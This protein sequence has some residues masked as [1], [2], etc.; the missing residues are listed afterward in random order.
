[1]GIYSEDD[2]VDWKRI[3]NENSSN[4]EKLLTLYL[5]DQLKL[6]SNDL[7]KYLTNKKNDGG[8]DA[9]FDIG[10]KII[11]EAKLRSNF[12]SDLKLADFAKSFIIAVNLSIDLIYIGT[13]N[14]LSDKT[15]KA[16]FEFEE[17]TGLLW[18]YIDPITIY[19]WL[20]RNNFDYNEK[21]VD[22][23]SLLKVSKEIYINKRF[24]TGSVIRSNYD[25]K[26]KQS[27]Y[28]S[29]GSFITKE[30]EKDSE[31][32]I[33]YLNQYNTIIV[34]GDAGSGKTF[35]I[36]KTFS[37]SSINSKHWQIIDLDLNNFS[38]SSILFI[39]ILECFWMFS[40]SLL[41]SFNQ[42]DLR[43]IFKSLYDDIDEVVF[44]SVLRAFNTEKKS[45]IDN[46]ILVK[47][48]FQIY[49]KI[50]S[51]RNLV[52]Y[53]QNANK[54]N[55]SVINFVIQ[56]L[57]NFSRYSRIV[58]EIRSSLFIDKRMTDD[59]WNSFKAEVFDKSDFKISIKDVD[60]V[61]IEKYIDNILQK[62]VSLSHRIKKEIIAHLGLSPLLIT[63]YISYLNL[64]YCDLKKETANTLFIFIKSTLKNH[65]EEKILDLSFEAL[66]NRNEAYK[67]VFYFAYLFGG[68]IPIQLIKDYILSNINRTYGDFVNELVLANLFEDVQESGILCIKHLLL[69][70]C[71]DFN[72]HKEIMPNDITAPSLFLLDNINRYDNIN[73]NLQS[74]KIKIYQ[75]LN[76][77]EQLIEESFNYAVRLY[78]DGSYQQ[79]YH[80]AQISYEANQKYNKTDKSKCVKYLAYEIKALM[81]IIQVSG[82]IKK[83]ALEFLD[84]R[85]KTVREL[86]ESNK[87]I[88]A[89]LQTYYD[90]FGHYSMILARHY[91]HYGCYEMSFKIMKI[92]YEEISVNSNAPLDI[93]LHIVWEYAISSKHYKGLDKEITILKSWKN[94]FPESDG[95]NIIYHTAVYQKNIFV[96]PKLAL[97]NI[98]DA[99][100]YKEI[101]KEKATHIH[102]DVH[103]WNA[104]TVLENYDIVWT[105]INENLEG[106]EE[107]GLSNELGRC[108]HILAFISSI[109]GNTDW[110]VKYYKKAIK[111][112][113][114][115]SYVEYLWTILLDYI[116]FNIRS[117]TMEDNNLYLVDHLIHIICNTYKFQIENIVPNDIRYSQIHMC[118]IILIY[119]LKKARYC[120]L[121]KIINDIKNNITCPAINKYLDISCKE[122][123]Y[124]VLIEKTKYYHDGFLFSG[125]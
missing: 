97:L 122:Q 20:I 5:I 89:G 29:L 22:L 80:Y 102:L 98:N 55:Y 32:M 45:A 31:E 101:N 14:H 92:A 119:E 34:E 82:F 46:A 123:N 30:R 48:L 53:F 41:Y 40:N 81:A 50:Q 104:E 35:F 38:S 78:F 49:T 112:F 67:Y 9:F 1:M 113:E 62:E 66:A 99:I 15:I 64:L 42:I 24:N 117:N 68:K 23:I 19:D 76:M 73:V 114:N 118:I 44:D 11:M 43:D 83:Y 86:F 8:Y 18:G 108:Y 71:I 54:T 90:L 57:N 125:C 72:R 28:N 25:E 63:N 26:N 3:V 17:K 109:N 100:K 121:P 74:A 106:I 120:A 10:K 65:K 88:L 58:V 12:E 2:S 79:C 51:K 56:F 60:S 6:N 95:L 96:K 107:S 75:V 4:F 61:A 94:K 47:F 85:V 37:K 93:R 27:S 21:Y 39:R 52:F 124:K 70:N 110:T 77:Y 7:N 105:E 59:E 13:N 36:K 115:E 33:K 116:V 84:D 16:L 111:I 91:I 87:R 103:K 69:E